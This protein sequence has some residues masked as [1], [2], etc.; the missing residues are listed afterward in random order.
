MKSEHL[1]AIKLIPLVLLASLGGCLSD[2]VDNSNT[3]QVPAPPGGST[4]SAPTISGSPS[5]LVLMGDQYS[6][7][8]NAS[9]PDNDPLTFSIQGKPTWLDF[10]SNSGA[11]TGTPQLGNIGS[12][13]GIVVSASDGSLSSS[14]PKFGVEVVQNADGSITLSW[15]APAQNIDGSPVDL[16]AYKFYYGTSPGNYSNQVQVNSPGIT[17]YVLEN[18]TPASYFVVATAIN[19]S[20]AESSFSNEASKTVN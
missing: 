12:Y 16:V 1:L 18:L 5:P 20:G 2:K 3:A 4:N 11:L 10:N 17:T 9:D 15:I 7:T 19:S 6:F 8:P 14:L 13:S